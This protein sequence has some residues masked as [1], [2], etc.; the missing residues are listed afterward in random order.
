MLTTALGLKPKFSNWSA[1][2]EK[3]GPKVSIMAFPLILNPIT[4]CGSKKT[5]VTS[6][7]FLSTSLKVVE[8]TSVNSR[9]SSSRMRKY[10]GEALGV[11]SLLREAKTPTQPL[12][13]LSNRSWMNFLTVSGSKSINLQALEVAGCSA[14]SR[15]AI[16]IFHGLSNAMP[17]VHMLAMLE[18]NLRETIQ[19]EE[20][21]N[22]LSSCEACA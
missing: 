22:K 9:C 7:V 13:S 3:S 17:S 5:T 19:L 6:G 15:Y 21:F 4:A 8:N 20:K 2:C 11:P 1:A 16:S 18:R 12:Y 14:C 10:F